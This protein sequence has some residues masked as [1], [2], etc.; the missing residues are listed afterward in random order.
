MISLNSQYRCISD[1]KNWSRFAVIDVVSI[2]PDR[3]SINNGIQQSN[4][5]IQTIKMKWTEIKF[6]PILS[7][8]PSTQTLNFD[9]MPPRHE[10]YVSK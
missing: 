2:D 3:N 9:N 1:Q 6:M 4:L 7:K 8:L 10:D 5:S